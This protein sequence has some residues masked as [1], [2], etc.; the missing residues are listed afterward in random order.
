MFNSYKRLMTMIRNIK[1]VQHHC[2]EEIAWC[3][4]DLEDLPNDIKDTKELSNI[5]GNNKDMSRAYDLGRME[6]LKELEKM[7]QEIND[8]S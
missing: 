7:L 2:I 5:I 4:E 1:D 8:K 6:T 3:R